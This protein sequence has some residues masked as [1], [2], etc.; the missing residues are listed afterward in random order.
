MLNIYTVANYILS[1]TGKITT[2]KLQKLCYY[3]QAWSLVWDSKPLFHEDFRAWANGPVCKELYKYHKNKFEVDVDDFND[4][5][6]LLTLNKS[7]KET[8][9][10]VLKS[11]G[12]KDGYYL[13][14]LSHTERPWKETRGNK[15]IGESCDKIITKD[16]MQEYYGGLCG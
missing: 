3:S 16:L 4:Q 1:R 10:S 5:N 7:Q 14:Q 6:K 13:M 8:I 2:I 9:N 12:K 11:Y 15:E